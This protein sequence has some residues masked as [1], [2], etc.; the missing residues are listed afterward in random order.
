MKSAVQLLHELRRRVIGLL[1]LRTRGVKVM[2]FNQRGELLLIRNSYGNR[3]LFLLPGG[4]IGPFETP[5]TAALREVRE[6]TGIAAERLV[7]LSVHHSRAEGK[8]D[9]IHLFSASTDQAPK[10][11]QI[12]VEEARFFSLDELP[13]G[14][15]P[16][17]L[18]RIEEYNGKRPIDTAW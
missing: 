9:T 16:A 13:D 14:V 5:A 11:D 6:E 4:G 3:Q 8:N 15:S 12:E 1:R 2:I 7:P 10:A 17:T 18:R